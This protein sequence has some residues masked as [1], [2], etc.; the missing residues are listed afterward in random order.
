MRPI[1]IHP[2]KP[3]S[4]DIAPP[5]SNLLG[6]M[7][8]DVQVVDV[9]G[10]ARAP[11]GS[12]EDLA[13]ATVL[14]D[15]GVSASF[16]TS[17]VAQQKVRSI[18]VTQHDSVVIA[19]LVR[20]DITVHR[21]SRHEYLAEDGMRYRQSSVVEV[22]FIDQRGEPLA[23]ELQD[24]VD[25]IREGRP[26]T[27]GGRAGIR[28]EFEKSL[29]LLR[30]LGDNDYAGDAGNTVRMLL[31]RRIPEILRVELLACR[32]MNIARGAVLCESE[33]EPDL[34]RRSVRPFCL[35]L[36]AQRV[37]LADASRRKR[38]GIAGRLFRFENEQREAIAARDEI[39]I[40]DPEH[41]GEPVAAELARFAQGQ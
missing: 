18:E 11:R 8:D 36:E 19:D 14:F 27:V 35:A 10:V 26:P 13:V 3:G 30:L 40:V 5:A 7:G 23:R 37:Q 34:H 17:R 16:E 15:N 22:P 29:V 31:K 41:R 2:I 33:R 12:T 21:M 24:V 9:A 25:A 20:Q 38:G 28:K 1:R 39:A 32:E 4:L 6:L